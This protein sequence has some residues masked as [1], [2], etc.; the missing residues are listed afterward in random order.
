MELDDGSVKIT[1]SSPVT[2]NQEPLPSNRVDNKAAGEIIQ[3]ASK[4]AMHHIR[5]KFNLPP[6]YCDAEVSVDNEK[7]NREELSSTLED[8]FHANSKIFIIKDP[9][10]LKAIR[11]VSYVYILAECYYE[12]GDFNSVTTSHST[13]LYSFKISNEK[14][15]L[16]KDE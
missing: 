2:T 15:L 14:Q 11:D 8:K 16:I 13:L 10:L 1:P 6:A 3:V 4:L 7:I 9:K 5:N 12:H